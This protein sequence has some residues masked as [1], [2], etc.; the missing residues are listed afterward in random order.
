MSDE[1]KALHCPECGDRVRDKVPQRIGHR[2]PCRGCGTSLEVVALHPLELDLAYDY[3]DWGDDTW[4][5]DD[6]D[7]DAA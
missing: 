5:E 6:W 2:L 7:E 3:E 1:R 4:D